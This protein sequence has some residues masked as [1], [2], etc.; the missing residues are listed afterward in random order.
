MRRFLLLFLFAACAR[1]EE[2]LAPQTIVVFNQELPESVAL[3]KFYAEKRGIAR[4]HLVPLDCP[5]EEEISREQYDATIAEPLRQV[6]GERGWWKIRDN[7]EGQHRVEGLTIHFVALIK[8]VPL[9]I[10]GAASY[11]DDKPGAGP[12]ESRNEASVDSELSALGLFSPQI[13]GAFNNR[14]FQS[15]KPIHEF[16]DMPILLVT[17]L[18][19]PD[20]STVRRMII[21]GIEAEKNGLWGR[22]FVDSAHNSNPG[23]Q[24]GDEWMTAIVEQLHKAG[25]PVVHEDT[26]AI[27]PDGYPMSDCALYYGWYAGNMA[28]PF[29]EPHFKFVPG[30]IA[31]HIHSFSASTLRDVNSGWTGPLLV[32]GA[33]ASVGNVYE[34]YLELT[35]HLDI[36]NDRLLHGFTFAE[37]VFMASRVLSWMGV[38]VGDPLYRPYY[39]WTQVDSPLPPKTDGSRRKN[40][41]SISPW[42][43]YHEFAVKNNAAGDFRAQARTFASRTHNAPAMEDLALMESREKSFSAAITQLQQARA[44]YTQPQD[45]V[46]CVLEECDALVQSGKPKRAAELA[47]MVLR[48]VPDSPAAPLLRKIDSDAAP[49]PAPANPSP[50]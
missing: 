9:K 15:Y 12:L 20:A 14:Y 2:P 26:A 10:R 43:S 48:I 42:R 23:F 8:G 24:V 45:I 37:S 34:P 32:R 49:K 50:R 33:A 13:S 47:R 17:R 41:K 11:A 38:A 21:D 29:T 35:A 46:R 44:G 16:A 22:A 27:F 1:A 28:G 30:A 31:A 36:L 5:V 18:D 19:A 40:A 6:F 39:L 7:A 3:A 25:I 4:D